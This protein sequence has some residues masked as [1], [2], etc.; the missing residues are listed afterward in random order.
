[1]P[2]TYRTGDITSPYVQF[3]EPLLVQDTHFIDCVR[4]GRRPDTPGERGLEVVRVLA[5]TDEAIA[6]GTPI[7]ILHPAVGRS[8]GKVGRAEVAS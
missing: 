4:T 3:V 7:R 1:M 8:A 2:V 6:S 5:A